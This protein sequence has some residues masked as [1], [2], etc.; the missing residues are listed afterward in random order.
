MTFVPTSIQ[1]VD[2]L[3][4]LDRTTRRPCCLVLRWESISVSDLRQQRKQCE[5]LTNSA[6]TGRNATT[7]FSTRSTMRKQRLCLPPARW[8]VSMI[9]SNQCENVL[10]PR[11]TRSSLRRWWRRSSSQSTMSKLIKYVHRRRA[12]LG[13]Q[14]K[15][16]LVVSVVFIAHSV[17]RFPYL[18]VDACD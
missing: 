18:I 5:P 16:I 12:E 10:A 2:E 7:S 1:C 14:K 17:F 6:R 8:P 9:Y 3:I 4:R 13:K 15:F 11:S